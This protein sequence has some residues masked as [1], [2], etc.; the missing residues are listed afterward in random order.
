MSRRGVIIIKKILS[1][2]LGLVLLLTFA[3]PAKAVEPNWNIKGDWTIEYTCTS[4]CSGDYIH[5]MHITVFNLTSGA[6]SGNGSYQP[7]PL[8]TWDVNGTLSGS[9]LSFHVLYTGKN[10]GYYSDSIGT[11]QPDG[12]LSGTT[13]S[14]TGQHFTFVSTSGKADL[15]PIG[16]ITSPTVDQDVIGSLVLQATYT[17]D[18]PAGVQWAVREGTCTAATNT[19][20]GNVDGFN[21]LYLW[22]GTIPNKTFSATIDVST[23]TTGDYCFVFNPG[24][25]GL[26]R[27]IRLTRR[28][29]IILDADGDGIPDTEDNCPTI[30]NSEQEDLDNDE[31]G[32]ACDAD[33]DNDGIPNEQ[34]LCDEK[35]TTADNWTEWGTN[36]WQYMSQT[37]VLGWY[38][39]K[40]SGPKGATTATL[41]ND[42]NYSCG[43]S[44]QQI[45]SML[46][47]LGESM[48][49]HWKYGLS[50]SVL[51][52]FALDC[53][54]GEIDGYYK[55]ESVYVPAISSTGISSSNTVLGTNY[56]LKASGKYKFANWASLTYPDA[57]YA[58]AMY[59]MRLPGYNNSD[60]IPQWINGSV[61]PSPVTNWLKLWV[62]NNA[63]EWSGDYSD[64]LYTYD[65]VGTGNPI[66]FNIKDDYY[67]DN[68]G[69]LTV[70]IYG[71]I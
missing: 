69:G 7:D 6:F 37:G 4:G 5:I 63:V 19:R 55:I 12:T 2:I 18:N 28:F 70:D 30:A 38:Q 65:F 58:D 9:D 20:A 23:W 42:L 53:K 48:R 64:H 61:F 25:S 57:G 13:I 40:P 34:D 10:A 50:S 62:N 44:G 11:V 27:D 36:R 68:R 71:Q 3:F 49:G 21:T 41:G 67:G 32:N 33:I 39:N 45:L 54:D 16:E 52:E 46:A 51:D 29:D 35:R 47:P 8:Y 14:S 60:T 26:E 17:D 1:I 56:K 24:E 66:F 31:E 59:S 22:T 43:C 15:Q